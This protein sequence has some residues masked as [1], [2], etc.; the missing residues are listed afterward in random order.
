[1]RPQRIHPR[2]LAAICMLVSSSASACTF[3]QTSFADVQG[4]TDTT[5]IARVLRVV[6]MEEIGFS[7][8]FKY[9]V[10][11]LASER[12]SVKANAILE[13][14]YLKYLATNINGSIRCPRSSGSGIEDQL[15]AG[16][17]YRLL[18]RNGQKNLQLNWA[19]RWSPA[20]VSKTLHD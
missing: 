9:T 10:E 13:V 11:I 4:Q 5:V 7:R 16:S 15:L 20:T 19:E 1:M 17:S 12:G 2:V 8:S 6:P 14:E 18:V 3:L